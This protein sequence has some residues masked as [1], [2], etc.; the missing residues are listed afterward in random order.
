MCEKYGTNIK[1]VLE[2]LKT[3][4]KKKNTFCFSKFIKL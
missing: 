1:N 3:L 2:Y 4:K